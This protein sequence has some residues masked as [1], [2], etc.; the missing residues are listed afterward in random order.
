M[1][2][3]F[4][5]TAVK[6]QARKLKTFLEGKGLALSHT[7]CLEAIAAQ[8]DHKSWHHLQAVLGNAVPLPPAIG[9]EPELRAVL[10]SAVMAKMP[11]LR[12]LAMSL[13]SKAGALPEFHEYVEDTPRQDDG[14]RSVQMG[15]SVLLDQ[16]TTLELSLDAQYTED[17]NEIALNISGFASVSREGTGPKD[18]NGSK[19]DAL[20][21]SEIGGSEGVDIDLKDERWRDSVNGFIASL[22]SVAM[23]LPALYRG[24]PADVAS[25]RKEFSVRIKGF[26]AENLYFGE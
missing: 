12:N 11:A 17:F 2:P 25:L 20:F 19:E 15:Y 23:T 22:D 26:L 3:L 14:F 6:A 9:T 16:D 8:Y 13:T 21:F 24:G 5:E 10:S 4:N 7:A 1:T 18:F